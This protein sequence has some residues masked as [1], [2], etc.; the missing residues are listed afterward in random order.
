MKRIRPR[1][2]D[3]ID[4]GGTREAKFRTEVRLLDPKFLD[5]IYG[6]LVEY[7]LN[8]AVLFEIGRG[9]SVH[10]Y[11]RRGI[12]AP[13]GVEIYARRVARRVGIGMNQTGRQKDQ[14]IS[15]SVDQGKVVQKSPVDFWP[16]NRR[17]IL[18]LERTAVDSHCA[19][20]P[21]E[22]TENIQEG[23]FLNCNG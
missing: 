3:Q 20:S 22:I 18:L 12:P 13:S 1:A 2:G 23:S 4:D 19:V 7:V 15:I 11:F 21:A 16:V 6:G 14:V 10:E 5:G 8:S 9:C 17:L